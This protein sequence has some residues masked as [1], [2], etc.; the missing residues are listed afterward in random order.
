MEAFYMG[1]MSE[2]HDKDMCCY[3]VP[4]DV[5]WHGKKEICDYLGLDP[6]DTEIYDEKDNLIE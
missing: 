3:Y 1:K 6:N 2:F 5:V 4:D